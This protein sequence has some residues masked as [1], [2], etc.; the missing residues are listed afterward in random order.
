MVLPPKKNMYREKSNGKMKNHH[1]MVD[2]TTKIGDSTS[3]HEEEHG[4]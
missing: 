2:K 4:G 3:K 1:W